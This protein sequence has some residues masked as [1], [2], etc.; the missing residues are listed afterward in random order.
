MNNLDK[1][2]IKEGDICSVID[3]ANEIFTNVKIIE[4]N[5]ITGDIVYLVLDTNETLYFSG[6][7]FFNPKLQ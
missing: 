1:Y 4:N 6:Q 3:Y 5:L 2:N 7:G